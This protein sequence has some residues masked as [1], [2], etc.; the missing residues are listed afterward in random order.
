MSKVN[1]QGQILERPGQAGAVDGCAV[2]LDWGGMEEENSVIR[3]LYE[4]RAK[5]P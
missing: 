3:G 2:A 4:V 1:L 5:S